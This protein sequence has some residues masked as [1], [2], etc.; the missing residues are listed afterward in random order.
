M[1]FFGKIL[2]KAVGSIF[3]KYIPTYDKN[4]VQYN[5][6]DIGSQVGSYLPFAH[7][8]MIQGQAGASV[9]NQPMMLRQSRPK[10]NYQK[11]KKSRKKK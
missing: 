4:G 1:G 5:G 3:A 6:G 11:T 10:R 9:F 2:G 8:G 7:G